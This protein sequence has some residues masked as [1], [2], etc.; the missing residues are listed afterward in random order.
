M[1]NQSVGRDHSTG[2]SQCKFETIPEIH[3]VNRDWLIEQSFINGL[4]DAFP[5][6]FPNVSEEDF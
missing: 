6:K 2:I 1:T 4:F 5:T 3:L